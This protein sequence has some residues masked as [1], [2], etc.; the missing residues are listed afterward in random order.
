MIAKRIRHLGVC[1]HAQ[2]PYARRKCRAAK[3]AAAI[4][5]QEDKPMEKPEYKAGDEVDIN[6]TTIIISTWRGNH[7]IKWRWYAPEIDV[8]GMSHKRTP[9]EAIADARATLGGPRCRCGA[10]AE[11]TASTGAACARHYDRYAA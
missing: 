10:V 3:L 9:E 7:G 1:D 11:M 2:T 8:A 4:A 6:G 5:A